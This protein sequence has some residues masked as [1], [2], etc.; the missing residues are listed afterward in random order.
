MRIV[1]FHT[2]STAILLALTTLA[3]Q[4]GEQVIGEKVARNG[5][6]LG[7]V[8][9][10]AVKM[11]PPSS[12]SHAHAAGEH[13]HDAEYDIHLEADVHADKN[14]PHGFAENAWI[15]YLKVG[16]RLEKIGADWVSDGTLL[17]MTASDG[18]HYGE[19]IKLNGPGKYRL[20]YHFEPPSINGFY[21]HIDKETGV[22]E[23]WQPFDM[24][25]EFIYVGTGKKGGY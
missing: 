6:L 18:P 2:A 13:V 12:V 9:L 16:Y 4:A 25:W 8:Y 15:P 11:E 22:S 7:A 10:Q 19:N 17:P 20:R 21:R 5:M 3:A 23:W 1:S 14:N 24:E